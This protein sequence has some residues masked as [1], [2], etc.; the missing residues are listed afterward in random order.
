M[1]YIA[2]L[3]ERRKAWITAVPGRP[4]AGCRRLPGTLARPAPVGSGRASRL[5]SVAQLDLARDAQLD[6]ARDAQLDSARAAGT[7][8]VRLRNGTA[9]SAVSGAARLVAAGRAVPRTASAR[10]GRAE[11]SSTVMPPT[12]PL[13]PAGPNPGSEGRRAVDGSQLRLTFPQCLTC[14]PARA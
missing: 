9:C 1:Q 8:P 13:G 6:S 12:N 11:M 2:P 3:C 5:D 7:T 4:A 14:I 10:D